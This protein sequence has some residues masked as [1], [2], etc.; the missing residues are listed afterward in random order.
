MPNLK[1]LFFKGVLSCFV[2]SIGLAQ[3]T[4]K[5][6]TPWQIGLNYG[7]TYQT[8][9]LIAD[10]DYYYSNYYF[11]GQIEKKLNLKKLKLA[12]LLE[13]S[14]YIGEYQLLNKWYIKPSEP[15]YLEKRDLQTTLRSYNEYAINVGLKLAL[16]II[17]PLDIYILASVGPMITTIETDRLNNGFAFSDILGVGF[18]YKI[19]TLIF[20]IRAT[21]RHNSNANLSSP[22]GGVNSLGLETGLKIV[23][24]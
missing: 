16:P 23:L 8:K 4:D 12:L 7:Q 19:N 6:K 17:K 1:L 24:D 9:E 15:N 21:A 20:D 5:S 18:N 2:F 3:E 13:P 14:I 10:Q 22:N 11:K